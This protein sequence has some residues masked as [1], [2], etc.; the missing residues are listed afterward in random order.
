MKNLDYRKLANM[1]AKSYLPKKT[2]T[3]TGKQMLKE[4]NP[5]LEDFNKKYG[6]NITRNISDAELRDIINWIRDN[7]LLMNAEVLASGAG[8]YIS[9][10]RAEIERYLES[11]MNRIQAQLGVYNAIKARLD[12]YTAKTK[13]MVYDK[14]VIEGDLFD[15]L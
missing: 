3:T 14:K 6:T 10:D 5:R 13:P 15:N 1:I 9:D 4:I 2:K 12:R 7:D 8:Y 11:F